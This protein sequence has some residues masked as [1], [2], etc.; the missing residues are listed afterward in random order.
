[1]ASAQVVVSVIGHR[2]LLVEVAVFVLNKQS[3]P[4][5]VQSSFNLFE[6]QSLIFRHVWHE[7]FNPADATVA[8]LGCQCAKIRPL[9]N[10]VLMWY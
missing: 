6:L 5:K 7:P 2:C 10:V 9:S 8:I 4:W 3:A 1:M